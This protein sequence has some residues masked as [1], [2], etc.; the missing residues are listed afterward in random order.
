[1]GAEVGIEKLFF[2]LASENRLGIL[3]ELQTHAHK[4]QGLSRIL[5]VTATEAFRQVQRLSDAGLIQKLSDGTYTTTQYGRL[6]M[7]FA[8]SMQFLS[9]HK[10]YFSSHDIGRLPYEFLNRISELSHA[11]LV[12]DTI[13]NLNRGQRLYSEAKSFAW[14]LA[15]GI[16]PESMGPIMDEKKRQGLDIKMLVPDTFPLPPVTDSNVEVRGL[17]DLPL[18]IALSDCGAVVCFRFI[19]GRIDYAGFSGDDPI[20]LNWARDLFLYYWE[21]GK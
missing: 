6:V 2:E 1:M 10:E 12:M 11:T 17:S 20:F 18:T 13:E 19:E 14:G 21:K 3:R 5:D 15:E 7:Q 8:T 4:L 16:I 9:M